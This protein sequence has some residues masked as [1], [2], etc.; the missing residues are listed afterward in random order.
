M[1]GKRWD[2][3]L[4]HRLGRTV[5]E[6]LL[7]LSYP[8]WLGENQ[9]IPLCLSFL[10]CQGDFNTI[11]HFSWF[12]RRSQMM[13]SMKTPLQTSR[14]VINAKMTLLVTPD[15]MLRFVISPQLEIRLGRRGRRGGGRE[16]LSARWLFS[17]GPIITE[18]LWSGSQ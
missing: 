12:L 14:H 3:F 8:G 13:P 18:E 7:C 4:V 9:V 15:P 6:C 17:L 1:W 16:W 2:T 10:I 5:A 11:C